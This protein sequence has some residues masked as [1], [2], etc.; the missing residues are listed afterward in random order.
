MSNKI[1]SRCVRD[2][3][4]MSYIPILDFMLP[5]TFFLSPCCHHVADTY[6]CINVRN[7]IGITLHNVRGPLRVY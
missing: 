4:K 1:S 5:G 7:R 3:L 2:I 6:V